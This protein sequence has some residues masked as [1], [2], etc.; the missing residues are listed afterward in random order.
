MYRTKRTKYMKISLKNEETKI[1]K[2]SLRNKIKFP[3]FIFPN[4]LT[5][6]KT[7]T[8][9]PRFDREINSSVMIGEK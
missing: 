7:C 5:K 1:D 8:K 2:M 9:D 3:S 6:V 4:V